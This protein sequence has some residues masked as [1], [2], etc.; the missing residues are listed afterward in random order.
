MERAYGVKAA[1]V[2][3]KSDPYCRLV[4]NGA[5]FKTPKVLQSLDP[6]WDYALPLPSATREAQLYLECWDYDAVGSHDFLGIV[7]ERIDTTKD[8]TYTFALQPRPGKKDKKICGTVVI[9][10]KR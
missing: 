6:V 1:D 9:G 2:T 3:G 4:V 5:K 7:E 10:V 8:A